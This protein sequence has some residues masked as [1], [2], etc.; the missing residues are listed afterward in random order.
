MRAKNQTSNILVEFSFSN[1]YPRPSPSG[2]RPPPPPK[3]T[4]PP[5]PPP[6]L[7]NTRPYFLTQTR[8]PPHRGG[9]VPRSSGAML[10]H[11]RRRIL[12]PPRILVDEYIGYNHTTIVGTPYGPHWRNLRRLGT[13]EVLS[14][15]RLNAFSHIRQDE[16]RRTLKTLIHANNG[17]TK[18]ELRPTLFKLIFNTITRMLAGNR[19][20]NSEEE[21][22]KSLDS[23]VGHQRLLEEQDRQLT[24]PPQHHLRDIPNVPTDPWLY[25]ASRPSI[26]KIGGYDIPR[27]TMLLV[28]AWAIQRDPDVW[29]EPT[30]FRPER[31]E[32][33]EV[34]TQM[35]MPF[36]MGRRACPGAGLG[37]R[38]VGL[39]LGSLI[40]VL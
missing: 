34:E 29:D 18:V 11:K 33:K 6:F 3:T 38:M 37:Q 39:A 10:H 25:P 19:Y 13:Q 12:Q 5:N 21:D 2:H 14:P 30:A 1:L 8:R 27:G 28:N 7:T 31:F 23:H 32:G 22:N 24:L 16:V 36:G 26:S 4:D 9:V 40:Q 17:F 35:L 20:F 15:A